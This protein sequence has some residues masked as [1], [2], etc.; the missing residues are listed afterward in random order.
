MQPIRRAFA[1]M[2]LAGLAGCASGS[3]PPPPPAGPPDFSFLNRLRLDVAEVLV[4]DRLPPP[5]PNDRG[6]RARPP[7]AEYL[8]AVAR[9]R[10]LAEGTSGRAVASLQDAAITEVRLPTRGSLFTTEIDTRFDGRMKLRIDV[11]GADGQPAGFTE[12]EVTRSQ[13]VLE[14]VD[15]AGRARIVQELAK[16][17]ADALNVELEF[18]ARRGLGQ[19]L[20]TGP[21]APSVGEVQQEDLAAPNRRR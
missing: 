20:L 3:S 15:A 17:L 4:E 13:S 7:V 12:A 18:Q 1:A 21:R 10:L 6:A 9:D 8:R 2:M 11:I 14:N 19:A 5:G 16:Q